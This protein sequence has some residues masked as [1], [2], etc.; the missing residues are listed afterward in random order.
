M[1]VSP[2]RSTQEQNSKD[3]MGCACVCA[4]ACVCVCWDL[5]IS[6]CIGVYVLRDLGYVPVKTCVLC[7][8]CPGVWYWNVCHDTCLSVLWGECVGMCMC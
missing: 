4:G 1:V 7:I 6:V 2:R 8:V 5:C 3:W